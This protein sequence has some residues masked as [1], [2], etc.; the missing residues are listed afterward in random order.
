[1]AQI[2]AY[3]DRYHNEKASGRSKISEG[4]QRVTPVKELKRIPVDPS[5]PILEVIIGVKILSGIR[6]KVIIFLK[7]I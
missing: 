4:D 7:A 1:M 2:R 6:G 3:G 5:R